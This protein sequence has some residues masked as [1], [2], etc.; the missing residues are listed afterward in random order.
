MACSLVAHM[1]VADDTNIW[2]F[3]QNLRRVIICF[4]RTN[5]NVMLHRIWAKY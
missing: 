5:R 4:T 1:I 2:Q 3:V